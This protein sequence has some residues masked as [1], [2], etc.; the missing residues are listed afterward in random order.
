MVQLRNDPT[1]PYEGK[2]KMLRLNFKFNFLL[3]FLWA[4]IL[5]VVLRTGIHHKERV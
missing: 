3:L 1:M 4:L 5:T 2:K